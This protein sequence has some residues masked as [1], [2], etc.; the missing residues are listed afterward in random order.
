MKVYLK[1]RQREELPGGGARERRGPGFFN[2]PSELAAEWVE[3]GLAY[4]ATKDNEIIYPEPEPELP[5]SFE[6]ALDDM[7]DDEEKELEDGEI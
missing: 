1:A 2:V 6:S 7:I 5:P 4:Y 3:A